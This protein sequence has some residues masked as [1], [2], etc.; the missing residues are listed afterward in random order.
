[1]PMQF[2]ENP[3]AAERV[4]YGARQAA[5]LNLAG[6]RAAR[7]EIAGW[8]DYRPT[9]LHR[10]DGLAAELGL[11]QV[12]YK[13][14]GE[15][16]A[17]KSFKALGGAYAVLRLLQREVEQ[18]TGLAGV[19]STSLRRGAHAAITGQ[20]TVASATDGNHGRA[21]A[22]GARQFGCRCVIYLHRGVSAGRERSIAAFGAE[23]RRV[24]GNYDDSVRHA[25]EEARR[26]GWHV[27]SDTSYDGY[28]EIPREVMQ[29]YT[30]MAGEAAEQLD[31]ERPSHIFVQGG[32]GG[33]AAA[34]AAHFWELWGERRPRVVVVE[35]ARADCL[36]QSA[37]VGRPA[38]A[39]GDLETIMAGLSCGEVSPLAW[40]ILA[41]G[42]DA[43]MTIADDDALDAM[44]LLAEAHHIVGGE[45]GVA[46]L[47]GLRAA[48]RDAAARRALRLGPHAAVLLFGTE[49]D[50]DP[51]LY[52]RIVGRGA[53]R[54]RAGTPETWAPR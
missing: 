16:F 26:H 30:V 43:F 7:A 53:E 21:V 51:E 40:S 47:A 41:D 25:A 18:R 42:A 38:P 34:V 33:L 37:R 49:G 52:R 6:F 4:A 44:R 50:T 15:R 31:A 14:E 1:M 9:P 11:N 3:R 24:A 23:V 32:V 29:G 46:G 35:P 5:I 19:D 45:S 22:W 54:V 10:L 28:T 2:V 12:W 39:H 13:D 27:V 8:P 20:I 48:A 17:L 36:Y